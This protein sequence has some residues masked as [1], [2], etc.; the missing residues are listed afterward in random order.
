MFGDCFNDLTELPLIETTLDD[1]VCADSLAVKDEDIT[2]IKLPE[3]GRGFV[4]YPSHLKT[5]ALLKSADPVLAT[6]FCEDL[7]CYGVTGQ[8]ITSDPYVRGLMENIAPVLDRQHA[9]YLEYCARDKHNLEYYS[10]PEDR[11]QGSY[12]RLMNNAMKGIEL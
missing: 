6:L 7:L 3:R 4:F 9:K 8:H 12:E 5:Y 2:K 1:L 10:H 11:Y